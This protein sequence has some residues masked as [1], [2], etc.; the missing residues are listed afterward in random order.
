MTAGKKRISRR[1]TPDI[2]QLGARL[3]LLAFLMSGVCAV[4]LARMAWLYLLGP[5]LFG[6]GFFS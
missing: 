3:F 2:S 1:G 6:S 5:L 4:E